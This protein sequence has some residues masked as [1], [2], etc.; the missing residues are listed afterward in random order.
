MLGTADVDV[1]SEQAFPKV[2][3]T[4]NLARMSDAGLDAAIVD[5][6]NGFFVL[7]MNYEMKIGNGLANHVLCDT[8]NHSFFCRIFCLSGKHMY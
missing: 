1:S 6:T 7:R 2:Q 5:G 3:V 8:L 4:L